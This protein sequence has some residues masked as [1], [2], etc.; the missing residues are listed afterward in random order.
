MKTSTINKEQKTRAAE[1]DKKM[2]DYGKAP[3]FIKKA[4]EAKAFIQKHGLPKDL[5]KK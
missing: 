3:F 5:P 1:V 4:E 2:K